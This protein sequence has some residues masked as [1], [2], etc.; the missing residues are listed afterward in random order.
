MAIFD[1]IR[2]SRAR[3]NDASA[4]ELAPLEPH[5]LPEINQRVSIATR[6]HVPVPSRV[7]D[8]A[9]GMV[10]LAFPALDLEFGEQVVVTW[11][12]EDTWYS[13][14]T[15]VLGLDDRASVPTIRIAAGGRLARYDERRTSTRRAVELPIELR[16]VNARGIR[17]GHELRTHTVEVSSEAVSFATSAPFA[18]GDLVEVQLHLGE[19]TADVVSARVRIVRVDAV[20]GSWRSTCSAAFDEILRSDRARIVALADAVGAVI[21]EEP[22]ASAAPTL[23]GVGGRDEPVPLGTYDSVVEWLRRRG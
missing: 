23:D 2:R 5:L 22:E 4:M 13:L 16:V 3:T 7:E 20:S 19:A 12:R 17:A 6:S 21:V 10:Q 14:E 1:R 18:P 8:V 11:E 15:R 9:D